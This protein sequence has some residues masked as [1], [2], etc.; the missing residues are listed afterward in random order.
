LAILAVAFALTGCAG[1]LGG[2]GGTT[3]SDKPPEIAERGAMMDRNE[4][5][6]KAIKAAS[7]ATRRQAIAAAD[8]LAADATRLRQLF[9]PGS[10]RGSE[11][12]SAIWSDPQGFARE[13]DNYE[14]AAVRLAQAHKTNDG[15]AVADGITSVERQCSSCHRQFRS[16]F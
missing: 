2:L 4:K 9:P 8:Q 15:R 5:N 3:T 14:R 1:S 16:L 6:L 12:S 13:L 10:E 7:S 11:A